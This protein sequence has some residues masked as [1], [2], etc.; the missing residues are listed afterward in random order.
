MKR[1]F[2][3]KEKINN[4]HKTKKKI[5][6]TTYKYNENKVSLFTL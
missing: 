2:L 4:I 6:N 3:Y 5:N 1:K